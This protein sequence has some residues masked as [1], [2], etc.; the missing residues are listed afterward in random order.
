MKLKGIGIDA[1]PYIPIS[2][3]HVENPTVFWLK[4]K[5]VG[6]VQKQFNLAEILE[7]PN[8]GEALFEQKQIEFLSVCDKVENFQYSDETP[9]LNKLGNIKKISDK[10]FLQ[11]LMLQ[12][13]PSVID[14]VLDYVDSISYVNKAQ[15]MLLEL[16]TYFTLARNDSMELQERLSYNCDNCQIMKTFENRY[17]FVE[18]DKLELKFIKLGEQD[19]YTGIFET[20][21]DIEKEIATVEEFLDNFFE[22]STK[23]QP[24]Q[25]A[26]LALLRLQQLAQFDKEMCITGLIGI[27]FIRVLDWAID[28]KNMSTLPY[29]GNYFEQPNQLIDCFKIINE[30]ISQFERIKLDN[31]SNKDKKNGKK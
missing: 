14:E 11:L 20:F 26:Y 4:P 28:C 10:K 19:D 31:M 29:P 17:C 23:A 12:L 25:P 21:P 1:I 22:F 2:E 8:G 6:L 30:T 5:T 13:Q 9:D 16:M 24:N 27:D 18:K 7:L 15:R 3:H